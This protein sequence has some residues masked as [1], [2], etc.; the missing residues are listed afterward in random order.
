MKENALGNTKGT[1]TPRG[2]INNVESYYQGGMSKLET[3][4][5]N[6]SDPLRQRMIKKQMQFAKDSMTK[7][8]NK[9]GSYIYSIE[10]LIADAVGG[11]L[12]SPQQFKSIAPN[13]AKFIR[14]NL[15]NKPSSKFV[16]FYASPLGTI[17]AII[18]SAFAMD[19]REEEQQPQMSAGALEL[20]QGALSA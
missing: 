1:I 6:T 7:W 3:E 10:E 12:M 19:D 2:F 8:R 15:N 17:L 14:D 20:G 5:N 13:T 16:K 9:T 18:M 11:Y 4:Y